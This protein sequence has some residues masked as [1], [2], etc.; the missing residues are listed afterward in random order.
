VI[1]TRVM[2]AA[3]LLVLLLATGC[4]SP[5]WRSRGL[6]ALDTVPVSVAAG[7]GV[8]VSVHATPFLFV[9]LGFSPVVSG[10]AGYEDRHLHGVWNEFD[11]PFPWS[12]W[13]TDFTDIPAHTPGMHGSFPD[14]VPV[15]YRWQIDRD[16]PLGEGHHRHSFEPQVRQWGRHPPYGREIGGGLGL[17]T[18]RRQLMWRDLHAELSEE[19]PLD[20]LSAPERATLWDVSRGGPDLAQPWDL[21]QVDVHLVLFGARVG[22]RPVEFVDLVVGFAGFDPLGDD[23]LAPTSTLSEL[24]AQLPAAR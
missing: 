21:F 22:L 24:A 15:M 1:S 18:P 23:V 3:A 11:A 5:Y 17:P 6:D 20:R 10:R 9:G 7:Y 19:A 14:G 13:L 2:P 8:A 4:R 16:A 12:L